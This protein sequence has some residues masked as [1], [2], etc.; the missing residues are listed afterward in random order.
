MNIK[1]S[2]ILANII[3]AGA[4]CLSPLTVYAWGGYRFYI[5]KLYVQAGLI[6]YDGGTIVGP[7]KYLRC[8]A[9]DIA[10]ANCS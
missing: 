6:S 9:L 2:K 8:I 1:I 4:V 3:F 10:P 5:T 7:Q